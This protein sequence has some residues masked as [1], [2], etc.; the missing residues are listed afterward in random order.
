MARVTVR[1]RKAV[2]K[3][4]RARTTRSVGRKKPRTVSTRGVGR[5]NPGMRSVK[6]VIQKKPRTRRT[7]DVGKS[8]SSGKLTKV[9]KGPATPWGLLATTALLTAAVTASALVY[10]KRHPGDEWIHEYIAKNKSNY[11]NLWVPGVSTK[12]GQTDVFI[13]Q[14]KDKQF[15]K[16]DCDIACFPYSSVSQP[17]DIT[18][19][20]IDKVKA[21]NFRP[22]VLN[23]QLAILMFLKRFRILNIVCHSH[24]ALLV[25]RALTGLRLREPR[26][27]VINCFGPAEFVPRLTSTYEVNACINW[28]NSND[29]LV[30]LRVLWVPPEVSQLPPSDVWREITLEADGGKELIDVLARCVKDTTLSALACHSLYPFHVG[31]AC[32]GRNTDMQSM[33]QSA[34]Q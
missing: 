1:G 8:S 11:A 28:I 20:L 3:K 14:Q 7:K 32:V 16:P 25:K 29:I 10:L 23:L 12:S 4:S 26:R 5:R 31:V 27:V 33:A 15:I 22:Q 34:S 6:K 9:T 24:G 13:R 30:R 19:A 21:T 18:A 17:L 2:R